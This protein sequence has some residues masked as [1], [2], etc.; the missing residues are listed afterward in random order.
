[1]RSIKTESVSEAVFFVRNKYRNANHTLMKHKTY[2]GARI[3]NIINC[4][5]NALLYATEQ[6]SISRLRERYETPQTR[7]VEQEDREVD[8][9]IERPR[10]HTFFL[11]ENNGNNANNYNTLIIIMVIENREVWTNSKSR[12]LR[13]EIA[14]PAAY[15][16][17]TGT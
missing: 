13:R 15:F 2:I 1:M 17:R 5:Y 4:I 14:G 8:R 12:T 3:H 7:Q 11:Y 9:R 10:R 6:T 16:L